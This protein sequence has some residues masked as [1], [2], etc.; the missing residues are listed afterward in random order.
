M[1]PQPTPDETP[2]EETAAA[3]RD[4]QETWDAFI[5]VMGVSFFPL[6]FAT[7]GIL[8]IHYRVITVA[9][10]NPAATTVKGLGRGIFVVTYFAVAGLVIPI[11][12]G[13]YVLRRTLRERRQDR[14]E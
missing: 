3:K 5:I 13:L 9:D 2:D 8:L 10:Y 11:L 7:I 1:Q 12:Y 6:V 14:N 4:S